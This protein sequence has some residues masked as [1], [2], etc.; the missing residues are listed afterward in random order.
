MCAHEQACN[1]IMVLLIVRIEGIEGMAEP[2]VGLLTLSSCSSD[3]INL[4]DAGRPGSSP[5]IE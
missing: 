5:R 4:S 2:L 3:I 1:S